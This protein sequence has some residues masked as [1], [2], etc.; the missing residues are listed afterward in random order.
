MGNDNDKRKTWME[1]VLMPVVIAV[2]G[3]VST[4][5]I[6]K[7][8]RDS[9]D[10]TVQVQLSSSERIAQAQIDAAKIEQQIKILQIFSEKIASK[11]VRERQQAIRLLRVVDSTFAEKLSSAISEDPTELPEVR[12]TAKEEI[13]KRL[14][15][16]VAA[17]PPTVSAGEKTRLSVVILDRNGLPQSNARA[18]ISS[19][20]GKF[21]KPG[22][23]FDP[24]S[25][26]HDPYVATGLTDKDGVFATSWVCNP[27]AAGYS[28]HIE[29]SKEGFITSSTDYTVRIRP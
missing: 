9:A 3:S 16:T 22:E 21:L 17:D 18:T 4:F 6:T 12:Q 25:R 24:K 8:Q 14:R 1:I 27:C 10:K 26:L 23:S 29:A 15:L 13:D 20:G 28:L 11:N 5:L 19:G 2:V 7:F